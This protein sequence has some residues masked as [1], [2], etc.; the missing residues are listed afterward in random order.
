MKEI[1]RY[2]E[3]DHFGRVNGGEEK[4]RGKKEKRLKEDAV[5]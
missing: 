5:I 4:K 3:R 1:Q 2:S